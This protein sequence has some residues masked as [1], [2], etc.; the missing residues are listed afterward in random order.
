MAGLGG[1]CEKQHALLLTVWQWVL[2][3]M[4]DFLATKRYTARFLNN[5]VK[6]ISVT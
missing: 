2:V 3:G 4:I 6:G 5:Q 1:G